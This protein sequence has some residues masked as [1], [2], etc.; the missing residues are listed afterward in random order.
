V[1]P[2]QPESQHPKRPS[3]PTSQNLSQQSS[4]AKSKV[5]SKG[6]RQ[7]SFS[8]G[9]RSL[10]LG[11][12]APALGNL[13]LQG[14]RKRPSGDH[15]K[16]GTS[17]QSSGSNGASKRRRFQAAASSASGESSFY[18]SGGG[19]R[20]YPSRRRKK[21]G[22]SILSLKQRRRPFLQWQRLGLLV[23][24]VFG[25]LFAL[26]GLL[27][28]GIGQL[29]QVITS[30]QV[31]LLGDP[32][33]A[34]SVATTTQ[35]PVARPASE[36]STA[37]DLLPA[38]AQAALQEWNRKRQ[39]PLVF[40]TPWGSFASPALSL[41]TEALPFEPTRLVG[42]PTFYEETSLKETLITQ[43]QSY[44]SAY[45]VHL[46][47]TH[48]GLE[49]SVQWNASEPVSSASVIKF[50]LLALTL[51]AVEKGLFNLAS[52][53]WVDEGSKVEGSGA[54]QLETLPTSHTLEET[55]QAMVE[56]SDNIATNHILRQL[57]GQ[58]PVEALMVASGF[59][60]SQVNDALPDL[61][62]R[63]QVSAEEMNRLWF[64]LDQGFLLKP[65]TREKALA[66]LQTPVN[67]LLIPAPI[68]QRPEGKWVR[69]A[70][71]TGNIASMLGDSA[72]VMLP[73]GSVYYLTI[74]VERP[75]NDERAQALI[76]DLSA[77]VYNW[78]KAQ[79]PTA[80]LLGDSSDADSSATATTAAD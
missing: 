61:A 79:A 80:T 64:N 17:G 53:L 52:R 32:N 54:W 45:R 13:W 11:Q 49:R 6:F 71:K 35:T 48:P 8:A 70:H 74:L 4:A 40:S 56:S 65:E 73:D 44:G 57:G 10:F 29:N 1:D 43:A 47:F 62:G 77:T 7:R 16:S 36:Q 30:V 23:L 18:S 19:G 38:S 51:Q 63:N 31:N 72:M 68:D 9:S 50:P 2:S 69:I 21:S 60:A 20:S 66:I 14:G 22:T 33:G 25:L 34:S 39:M 78:V 26:G 12:W 58:N 5:T 28:F 75:S 42:L 41:T 37:A 76:Q 3:K 59:Q 46:S 15:S 24:G 67:R 27:S 55:L